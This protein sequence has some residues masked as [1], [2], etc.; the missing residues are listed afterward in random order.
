M[1]G[2]VP[3]IRR[4]RAPLLMAGTSPAMTMQDPA[5]TMQEQ[6]A[7]Q[8]KRRLQLHRHSFVG[9]AHWEI[10]GSEFG[11]HWPVAKSTQAVPLRPRIESRRHS[12]HIAAR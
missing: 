4:G 12:P 2:L 6:W 1:A 10:G 3:A 11:I 5:M 7:S 9:M 8:Q